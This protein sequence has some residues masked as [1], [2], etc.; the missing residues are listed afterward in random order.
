MSLAL[1]RMNAPRLSIKRPGY[2]RLGVKL[3][4]VMVQRAPRK[5]LWV[6]A[7]NQGC[8]R[9]RRRLWLEVLGMHRREVRSG[10]V[11]A[12]GRTCITGHCGAR[13]IDQVHT[14]ALPLTLLPPWLRCV[15]DGRLANHGF[16]IGTATSGR[17]VQGAAALHTLRRSMSQTPATTR[18]RP[19]AGRDGLPI[20]GHSCGQ[21]SA[22]AQFQR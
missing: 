18:V 22:A 16:G 14:Q 7:L 4:H 10:L 5:T 17:L 12:A 8:R 3:H 20:T 2:G 13:A 1:L 15:S 6:S 19:L 11:F 21:P 9:S